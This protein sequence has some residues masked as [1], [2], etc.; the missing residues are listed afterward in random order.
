[1]NKIAC[2]APIA[3]LLLLCGCSFMQREPY[4]TT[5]YFEI[6]PTQSEMHPETGV[7]DLSVSSSMQF[8]DRMLFRV[9]AGRM[10]F[11]EYNR[12]IATPE[13]L[14]RRYLE[15]SLAPTASSKASA[16]IK[17]LRFDLDKTD[18]TANC[19]ILLMISKDNISLDSVRLGST[20]KAKGETATDFVDAMHSAMAEIAAKI[21]AELKK[22]NS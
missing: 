15:I 7:S 12:W 5:S 9:G 11:D 22:A 1:M 19:E 18:N 4:R 21:A 17:I 20:V 2:L 3:A 13:V 8:S 16:Q 10:E 14:L 6:V